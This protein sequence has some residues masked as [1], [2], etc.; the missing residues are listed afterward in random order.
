M[1]RLLAGI[2]LVSLLVA[3]IGIMNIMRVGVTG[4]TREIGLRMAI[5]AKPS[6]I[7]IQFVIEAVALSRIGGAF[8]V[9][10]GVGTAE[11]LRTAVGWATLV[12]PQIIA[13]S[14]GF[15][16]FVGVGFGR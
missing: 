14:L 9:A 12:Q 1:T 3:G 10:P 5:G 8:G 2:A 16:T 7:R 11:Y 13:I 6:D 15:G 4:R